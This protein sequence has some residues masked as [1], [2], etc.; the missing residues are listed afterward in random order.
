M[1]PRREY[2]ASVQ[3]YVSNIRP[4]VLLPFLAALH[5]VQETQVGLTRPD[6]GAIWASMQLSGQERFVDTPDTLKRWLSHF[7]D[8]Y[9]EDVHAGSAP[10][11]VDD[12]VSQQPSGEAS[13]HRSSTSAQQQQQR[14][15]AASR[16]LED[17]QVG[18]QLG[19]G[20][21]TPPACLGDQQPDT[22]DAQIA[23]SACVARAGAAPHV[24][25][26]T[27]AAEPVTIINDTPPPSLAPLEEQHSRSC[28]ELEPPGAASSAARASLRGHSVRLLLGG[29]QY[30]GMYHWTNDG[31]T[32]TA[33]TQDAIN[34]LLQ[35]KTGKKKR[36]KKPLSKNQLS[37]RC[38]DLRECWQCRHCGKYRYIAVGDHRTLNSHTRKHGSTA[39]S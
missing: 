13:I 19:S 25:Q 1:S 33:L 23:S 17:E 32:G 28:D 30:D 29:W 21:L 38:K 31:P 27:N 12:L 35:R 24:E 36:S 37:K 9:V 16:G 22:Y 20:R 8:C 10:P 6:W 26:Q 3:D 15:A 4:D 14:S 39:A 18:L 7:W 11:L 34:G 2:P 5:A